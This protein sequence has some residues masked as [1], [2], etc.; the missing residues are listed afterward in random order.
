VLLTPLPVPCLLALLRVL[1]VAAANR[2]AP[3]RLRV[4]VAH[5]AHPSRL[6][7]PMAARIPN[8]L[9][10]I[11]PKFKKKILLLFLLF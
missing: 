2:R 10:M 1:L 5:F 3:P 6:P 7:R 9:E 8:K 4:L 11:N